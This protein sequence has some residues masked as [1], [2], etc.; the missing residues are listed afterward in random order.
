MNMP[1]L[2]AETAAAVAGRAAPAPRCVALQAAE[3]ALR[4]RPHRCR[5]CRRLAASV[6]PPLVVLALLLIVWEILCSRPGATLPPPPI[7]I[8]TWDLI[9]DPFFDA[10]RRTTAWSGAS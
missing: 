8:D 10:A 4:S 2:K 3:A 5:R 1:M 6:V 7:W 9:V